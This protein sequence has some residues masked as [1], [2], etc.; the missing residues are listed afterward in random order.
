LATALGS[1]ELNGKVASGG[2]FF[3][4]FLVEII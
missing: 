3:M 2:A 1:S 4:G